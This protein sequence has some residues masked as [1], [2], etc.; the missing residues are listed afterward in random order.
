MSKSS[1]ISDLQGM[2]NGISLMLKSFC[3]LQSESVNLYTN[4]FIRRDLEPFK[5]RAKSVFNTPQENLEQI[6][7]KASS[8]MRQTSTLLNSGAFRKSDMFGFGSKRSYHTST[9]LNN[10][11]P[12]QHIYYFGTSNSKAYST[13]TD[14]KPDTQETS[15]PNLKTN[16]NVPKFKHKVFF[17]FCSKI[18]LVET[19]ILN[20]I[21][22][23][24]KL[25]QNAKESKVPSSRISRLMNFGNLAAGLGAGAI[26]ELTKR[27]LGQNKKATNENFDSLINSS[28]SIFLTEDNVQRVVDTLCKVRGAAL[29]L[30]QMLSLQ[31]E[32]LLSPTLQKIF[33]RV[34]QSAD[35]M[36][37]SQTEKV[38]I[39]D[40]G[41]NYMDKFEFFDT[42]PFA[43]ASIGQ[44]HLAHVKGA[45]EKVAVKIQYPGVAESIISDIDNLMSILNVANLLPKGMYVENVITVM[46]RELLDECDYIRE[47]NCNL[48]F[49]EFIRDDSVF[50]VPKVNMDLTTKNILVCELVDGEPFDK[51]E[52]LPQ[53]QRNLIG[54][55]ILRLCLQELFVYNFMQTDPN[56]SNFFFNKYTNKV[57]N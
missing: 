53:E 3:K 18:P 40:W 33:E 49:S 48:K 52:N 23:N 47:A 28:R 24:L 44:V 37:F 21:K 35:F 54:Y 12:K 41:K 25:N 22:P 27:A 38:L 34:R 13:N 30:G 45:S 50:L 55:N 1:R 51:C 56:W 6:A 2:S 42:Q 43:A 8:F 14:K 7:T 15:K 5:Q 31:D 57:F 17:L 26:N 9:A 29:K 39:S 19:T 11:Y 10:L 36:P 16:I 46:K 20:C 4:A 32:T